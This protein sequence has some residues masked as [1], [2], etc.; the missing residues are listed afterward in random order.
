MWIKTADQNYINLAVASGISVLLISGGGHN[1]DY[2]IRVGST[3]LAYFNTEQ[4]AI[5]ALAALMA[6][7]GFTSVEGTA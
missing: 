7:A 5:D 3:D 2:A 6:Q 4:E 1:G